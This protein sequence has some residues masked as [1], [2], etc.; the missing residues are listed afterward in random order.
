V[1]KR[2]KGIVFDILVSNPSINDEIPFENIKSPTLIINAIDDPS[3]LIE[4]AINLERKI[5]NS[6]LV[7]FDTGG[8]LLLGQE[9]KTKKT[10]TNFIKTITSK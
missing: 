2:K 8:H 10:I 7:K 6:K 5:K 9:E 4:G 1:T 3:A